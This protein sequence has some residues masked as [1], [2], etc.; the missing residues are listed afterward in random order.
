MR[1]EAKE[2][3]EELREGAR[4]AGRAKGDEVKSGVGKKEAAVANVM[5]ANGSLKLC[6]QQIRIRGFAIHAS[7]EMA[8]GMAQEPQLVRPVAHGEP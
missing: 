3:A 5:H 4:R 8:T 2:V 1:P 6:R 7:V